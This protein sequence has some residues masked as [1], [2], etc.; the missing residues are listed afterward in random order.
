MP[1]EWKLDWNST[2]DVGQASAKNLKEMSQMNPYQKSEKHVVKKKWIISNWI[3]SNA[4]KGRSLN[5]WITRNWQT[6]ELWKSKTMM[7]DILID[8][9]AQNKMNS[10]ER[11]DT[12]WS[13]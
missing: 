2:F 10:S 1:I 5:K 8:V 3:N 7:G 9:P 4:L 13:T 6:E 11:K 12:S